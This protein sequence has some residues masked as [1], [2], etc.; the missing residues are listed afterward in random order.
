MRL[1]ERM[2]ECVGCVL[3]LPGH[4]LETAAGGKR[5]VLSEEVSLPPAIA[6]LYVGI[7]LLKCETTTLTTG[8]R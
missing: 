7:P 5:K 2:N 1:A 4:R 6:S 8:I 3:P